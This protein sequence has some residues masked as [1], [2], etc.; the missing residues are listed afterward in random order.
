ML[1]VVC[2][3]SCITWCGFGAVWCGWHR[4]RALAKVKVSKA[5]IAALDAETEW[6]KDRSERFLREH[7]GDVQAALRSFAHPTC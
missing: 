4:E 7:G 2:V 5:D 6:G 3:R 1:T